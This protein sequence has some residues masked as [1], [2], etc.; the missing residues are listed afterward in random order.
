MAS[1]NDDLKVYLL[2]DDEW[3]MIEEIK[4]LMNVCI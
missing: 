4:G 2:S 1:A 3:K